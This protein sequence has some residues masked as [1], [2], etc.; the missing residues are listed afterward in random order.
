MKNFL[1]NLFVLALFSQL[2]FHLECYPLRRFGIAFTAKMFKGL[3]RGK[4][5]SGQIDNEIDKVEIEYHTL[6]RLQEEEARRRA[7]R[8]YLVPRSGRTR[9]MDDFY[10][11]F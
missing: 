8:K 3:G 7:I 11:R 1:I 10:S 6:K 9:V 2:P 4:H 5:L